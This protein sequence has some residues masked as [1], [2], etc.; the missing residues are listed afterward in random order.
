MSFKADLHCH[1]TCS[2]GSLTP[3]QLVL[4]AKEIG[5]H[6]LSITDH[7]TIDAYETAIPAAK[8]AGLTLGTGVEFSCMHK[9]VSVH[10]LGYDYSLTSPAIKDLCHRHLKRRA[11]RNR[12]ILQ[13]LTRLGMPISEEELLKMGKSKSLGRPHIAHLM[14]KKGYVPSVRDAFHR[15]LAE[16]KPAYASGEP[17]MAEET[18]EILHQAGGKAFIAHPQL[19]PTPVSQ[20]L[21]LQFDGIECFYAKLGHDVAN[22]WMKIAAEKKWLISGGSDFHG[23]MR[24]DIELGSSFVD[25]KIFNTIFQHAVS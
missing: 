9:K 20:I 18:I 23:D 5:L 19:L 4:R 11:D 6:A 12:A 24:S 13:N 15:Y 16:N 25:E 21:A 1:S 14:V 7:D 8:K 2:D 22:K 10:I 3:E 17:F